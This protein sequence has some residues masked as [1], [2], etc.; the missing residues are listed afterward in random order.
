METGIWI[1]QKTD[2]F[3]VMNLVKAKQSFWANTQFNDRKE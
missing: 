2:R 3:V 1:V